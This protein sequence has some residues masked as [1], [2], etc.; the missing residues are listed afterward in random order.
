M[1]VAKKDILTAVGQFRVTVAI[2]GMVHNHAAGLHKGVANG[3]ADERKTG[4]FQ[5]FAHGFG[6]WRHRREFMAFSK[7]VD[8]RFTPNKRP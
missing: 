4:F 8:L 7:V 2:R 1:R 6:L 5:A 3:R